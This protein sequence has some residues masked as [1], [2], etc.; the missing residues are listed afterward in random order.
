ME[1]SGNQLMNVFVVVM[2]MGDP[3]L[4]EASL[5]HSNRWRKFSLHMTYTQQADLF[6]QSL[7]SRKGFYSSVTSFNWTITQSSSAYDRKLIKSLSAFEDAPRLTSLKLSGIPHAH[8]L[9]MPWTQITSIQLIYNEVDSKLL[10]RLLSKTTSLERCIITTDVMARPL[11]GDDE[12]VIALNYLHWLTITKSFNLFSE[13]AFFELLRLPSLDVLDVAEVHDVSPL[14]SLVYLSGCAITELALHQSF[15]PDHSLLALAKELPALRTLLL[16]WGGMCVM[17]PDSGGLSSELVL[18]MT[19][20]E[21]PSERKPVLAHLERLYLRNLFKVE[22]MFLV[23]MIQSR[24]CVDEENYVRLRALSVT[25]S[26]QPSQLTQHHL[27]SLNALRHHGLDV[28]V[29]N[30]DSYTPQNL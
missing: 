1:R 3:S 25:F 4:L 22:G 23:D 27:E 16:E 10:H 2:D 17:L 21:H 12:P 30:L 19:Y 14:R 8:R 26:R 13:T 18:A 7:S 29:P 6:F 20:P 11:R 15:F 24:V 9:H 28:A 5:A